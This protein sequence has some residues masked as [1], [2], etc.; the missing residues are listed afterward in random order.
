MAIIRIQ[1]ES[2]HT[3]HAQ[4]RVTEELWRAYL[5]QARSVRL[6][7]RAGRRFEAQGD[8]PTGELPSASGPVKSTETKPPASAPTVAPEKETEPADFA[9]RLLKAKKKAMEDRDKT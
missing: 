8:V 6:S 4:H 1:R 7:A 3:R 2:R 5:A 9:S